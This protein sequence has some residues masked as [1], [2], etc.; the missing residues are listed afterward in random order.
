MN[1]WSVRETFRC[2][3]KRESQRENR[4][5]VLILSKLKKDLSLILNSYFFPSALRYLIVYIKI[6]CW[7]WCGG[8]AQ[9]LA[10]SRLDRTTNSKPALGLHNELKVSLGYKARLFFYLSPDPK[11]GTIGRRFVN[12]N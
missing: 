3:V 6:L 4:E 2:D 11:K 1:R 10:L 5:N 12:M 7:D 8:E 9:V